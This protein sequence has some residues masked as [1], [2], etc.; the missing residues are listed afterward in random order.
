MKKQILALAIFA[1]VTVPVFAQ[2][3]QND[4]VARAMQDEMKRSMAEL[5]IEAQERP[6]FIS[7]KIVD[8]KIMVA[9]A[10]FGA[11]TSSGETH[12]RFLAVTVRV[13]GYD[14]DNSNFSGGIG[15]MME[16]VG[17]LGSGSNILPLDDNYDE[18][19]RKLWLATDA[20]YKK[21][22]ED[23]S[24]KKAADQNRNHTETISSF[25][26]EP[27]RKESETLPLI[28]AKLADAENLVRTASAVFL[29][30]PSVET[31]EARLEVDNIT[32]RFL[33]SEGTSYIRQVPEV[34]FHASASLQNATGES[35]FDTY[36]AHARSLSAL[37]SNN[38]LVASTKDISDRLTARMSGKSARHYIGPVLVEGKA[39]DE[40]FA[41]HFANHLSAQHTDSGVSSL[42][43][44][45][46]GNGS[47]KSPSNTNMIDKIG[48]HVLPEFLSV[49]NN[50]QL[51]QS[52]G[53]PLFG[54]YKFD[55]EGV[56][57]QETT[58]VKSGILKTLLTSRTPVRGI[59]QS[60]GSMRELD[61][62]PGN[63]FVNASISSPR[64]DL[65]KQLIELVAKQGLEYGIILRRLSGASATEA[66]RIYPDGHEETLRNA[67]ITEF[68]A[69]S[70]KSILAVST[71][72]A[73]YTEHASAL[74]L[75]SLS[76]FAGADLVTYV[77][78]DM[79]FEEITINHGSDSTPKPPS[80]S[81][82]MNSKEVTTHYP[83]SGPSR[84]GHDY[85]SILSSSYEIRR[86]LCVFISY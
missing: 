8:R 26:Q 40:L 65:R 14:L 1:L 41:H 4:I 3:N 6:Y 78:P 35:F 58:L 73:V 28:D 81:S 71:E 39:A 12:N 85:A 38:A 84:A 86:P 17:S 60:T 54:N 27:A 80:I 37:P 15:S 62:L 25:S 77:V 75:A 31:A 5:Q 42:L 82:P 23:L 9:H 66:V 52:D 32:E 76:P 67:H 18:L 2:Q 69:I 50:P 29:K 19:R 48:S 34:F 59:H 30:L 55:E 21:A 13:G 11:L 43:T 7:Y 10:S 57:S 56:P 33:N 51:T 70:F 72:R 64:E 63:L 49:V 36:S 22:V 53:Q 46:S 44:M 45:L 74:S 24:A 47:T 61:V 83:S 16:L 79:L 68:T 20:T